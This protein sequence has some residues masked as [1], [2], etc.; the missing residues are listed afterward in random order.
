MRITGGRARGRILASPK[1]RRIRPTADLV[2]E[3]VFNILGHDLEGYR[4]LDLFAG[5]G[6][7]G[8][9]A[10]SRNAAFAV[11]V[12]AS[13]GSLA[14]VRRNLRS[15]G[16]EGSGAAI[17]RDLRRG[18]PQNHR[19]FREPFDLV[20]LDPPYGKGLIPPLLE[21]M[22]DKGIVEAGSRIVVESARSERL[23][24]GTACLTLLDRRIY[25]DTQ[26]AFYCREV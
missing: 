3:A 11:F 14:I 16:F 23:P 6:A 7:L 10:L 13:P 24:E 5:T 9:E 8:M 26:V 17:R 21:E 19:L 12:D 22:P 25:G 20:F 4:V 1:G 18:I 2:R 15:C